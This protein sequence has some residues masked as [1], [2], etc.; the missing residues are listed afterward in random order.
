MRGHLHV[1]IAAALLGAHM[2]VVPAAA[3]A[4]DDRY[5]PELLAPYVPAVSMDADRRLP[6]GRR[7]DARFGATGIVRCGHA[8]G[9][10]QLTL[11]PDVITTAAHVLIGND[12]RP[13]ASACTFE[14]TMGPASHAVAIDMASIRA[15]S[16]TPLSEP[17]V[18]DWAV[19][20]LAKPVHGAAPYGLA[21]AGTTPS[22]VVMCAGG[23]GRPDAMAT[24]R[25]S[26][27]RV[28]A[29]APD[30]IREF[31][32]DCSAAPGSS[33]GAL[34]V[35]QDVV[36]IYVGFRSASPQQAQ[37]FSDTHY[38]FAITVDGPFRRALHALASGH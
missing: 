30:G 15:G 12:G 34:I 19:A 27:R 20:R 38:N 2:A 28:L 33:G 17:A 26:L 21:A 16:R 5:A 6:R 25:C 35:G 32:I 8:I 13:R 10:A 7:L 3:Q 14:P 23:N 37:A 31:A 22:G 24:E 9:T 18:R 4:P 11:K 36:A 29:T 1:W